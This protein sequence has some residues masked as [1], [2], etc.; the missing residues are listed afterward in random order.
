MKVIVDL[1]IV[2]TGTNTVHKTMRKVLESDVA[3]VP[4]MRMV[5]RIWKKEREI[6]DV[7]FNLDDSSLYLGLRDGTESCAT[8]EG[9]KEMESS[10]RSAGWRSAAE[11]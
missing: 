6:R 8:V 7:T 10:Y 2:C 11:F 5:D 1:A 3:L 4:G 9:C